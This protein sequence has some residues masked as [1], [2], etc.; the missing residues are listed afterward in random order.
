M[1]GM[2]G[3]AVSVFIDAS[4]GDIL[5]LVKDIK[6]FDPCM[7]GC[8][9]L[10]ASSSISHFSRTQVILSILLL[11]YLVGLGLAFGLRRITGKRSI[12]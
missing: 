5:M 2:E 12:S 10:S 7:A 11:L 1:A 4:S 3:E 6:V 9:C 8:D